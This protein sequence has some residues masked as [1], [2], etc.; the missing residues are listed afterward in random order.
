MTL[1]EVNRVSEV[2]S[3]LADPNANV[4]FGAVVDKAYEGEVQTQVQL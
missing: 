2:V 1:I 4:I 3:E